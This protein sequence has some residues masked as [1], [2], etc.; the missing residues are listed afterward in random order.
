MKKYFLNT[1]LFF[2]LFCTFGCNDKNDPQNKQTLDNIQKS[3]FEKSIP[4]SVA[5]TLSKKIPKGWLC[6][7]NGDNIIIK[8]NKKVTKLNLISLPKMKSEEDLLKKCGY[9]DDCI[10]ELKFVKKLTIEEYTDMVNKKEK[11]LLDLKNNKDIGGK[12][13]YGKMLSVMIDNPIPLYYL[14]DYSIYQDL[15]DT[16][17]IQ[18]F[19]KNVAEERDSIIKII[20]SLLKNYEKKL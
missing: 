8:F 10:I 7:A 12:D 2:F 3:K 19:P 6:T 11:L 14:E 16:M 18:I 20:E 4:D 13:K 15:Q 5:E 9:E 17:H 1:F